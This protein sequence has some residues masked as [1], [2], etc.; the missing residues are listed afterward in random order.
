[1]LRRFG[2]TFLLAFMLALF[3]PLA[4]PG[5]AAPNRIAP[6]S[7]TESMLRLAPVVVNRLLLPEAAG[8]QSRATAADTSTDVAASSVASSTAFESSGHSARFWAAIVALVIV[9]AWGCWRFSKRGDDSSY[10]GYRGS[11]TANSR[12][13]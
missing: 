1:M 6:M 5:P 9:V 7:H 2:I 13:S 4:L 8:A 12:S 3:L 11:G 10:N